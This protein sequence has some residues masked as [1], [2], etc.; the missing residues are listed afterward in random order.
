[1]GSTKPSGCPGVVATTICRNQHCK[2]LPRTGAQN[3]SAETCKVS[4]APSPGGPWGPYSAPERGH[5]M[6]PPTMCSALSARGPTT[7]TFLSLSFASG[8]IL[9]VA[10]RAGSFFSRTMPARGGQQGGR[11]GQQDGATCYQRLQGCVRKT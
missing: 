7:Q 4:R 5:C 8:S 1:M 11:S 2:R 3:Q 10:L 6:L 9:L